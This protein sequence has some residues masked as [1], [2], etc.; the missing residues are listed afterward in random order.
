MGDYHE[1]VDLLRWNVDY[2]VGDLTGGRFGLAAL[3]SVQ[4]RAYM[5]QCL[6]ELG[7]FEVGIARGEEGIRISE[8]ADHPFSMSIA[9]QSLG[10]L[11][12]IRGDISTAVPL[13]ER[14]LTIAR[15]NEIRQMY[16]PTASRLGLSYVL[17]GRTSDGLM[18]LKRAVSQEVSA[19]QTSYIARLSQG[20]VFAGRFHEAAESAQSAL[21]IARRQRERGTEAYLHYILGQA[22]Y[23]QEPADLDDADR[24]FRAAF[25]VA[26]EL[27]MRPLVAHC[28]VGLGKLYHRTDRRELA[29]EHLTTATALYRELGMTY[30]LQKLKGVIRD[31]A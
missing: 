14:A 7:S 9:C 24:Y 15:T 21:G 8:T 25:D 6:A 29:R 17:M 19:L 18:L 16:S 2:L 5:V 4:S 10:S 11:H 12:L 27:G 3:P 13:L 20:H 30:W 26:N 31:I 1:A 28:R 23:G 22:A